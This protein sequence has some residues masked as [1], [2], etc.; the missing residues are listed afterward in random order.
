MEHFRIVIKDGKYY[1]ELY[2][3]SSGVV[4]DEMGSYNTDAEA[5]AAANACYNYVQIDA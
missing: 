1:A 2:N 3:I 4:A 5:R